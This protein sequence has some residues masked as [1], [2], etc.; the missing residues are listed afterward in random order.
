MMKRK[1][2]RLFES[3]VFVLLL[4]AAVL[5]ADRVL[6]RKKSS[7]FFSPFFE[8]AERCDVLFF[9][10]SR[11][12]NGVLPLEMWADY[13][14]A[15][16]NLAC[17]GNSLP[18]SYWSMM[19]ALDYASPQL[20]VLAV[21]GVRSDRK[22]SGSSGDLHT[23]LDFFPLTRTKAQA[24]EDLTHDP[25]YPDAA[26]DDGNLYTDIRWE[27]YFPLGKYHSRWSEL[28]ADDFSAPDPSFRGGEILVGVT[29]YGE[30][31]IIDEDLYAEEMGH[32]F[33]YLRRAVE[34]CQARGI[35]VLLVNLPQPSSVDVQ[36]HANTV[37]S[38]AEEYGVGYV[39]LSRLDSIV[40]Y[41][42]DCYDEQ[43]H[44][45]ASGSQKVSDFL[46]SYIRDHY[47]LPDRRGDARYAHWDAH[48]SAYIGRKLE[49]IR[50]QDALYSVLLLLHDDDFDVRMA[51]R[52][53]APLFSDETAITLV[54][55]IAREHV[56]SGSEYDL[57]SGGM[58]PLEGFD[59]A[60]WNYQPYF[61]HMKEGVPAE[62]TGEEAAQAA[63]AA[64]GGDRAAVVIEISD[65][66]TGETV[67]RSF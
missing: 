5:L 42:V 2:L 36:K 45:N 60:L 27:Y 25:E 55:N 30:Y 38:I 59:D 9:G 10:D 53:D 34:A 52:D 66:R 50:A 43:P 21:N 17:Y 26:D 64:F 13:G 24:I 3:C 22:I 1:W 32:G 37:S 65:R 58:Y 8:E 7:Q 39:D 28:T 56:L 15:G 44:L 35:D 54:H 19:N 49:R 16:Y 61:L 29:P 41:T 12:M 46:A 57:W 47:A 23:A 67:V 51:I 11:F 40:D 62:L 18:V 4:A 6:E 20:I 14:V 33:V 63:H 31:E 48:R